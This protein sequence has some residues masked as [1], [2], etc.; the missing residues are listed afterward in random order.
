MASHDF[1]ADVQQILHLV[2]HA[3]YS[4]KEVFLRELISNASDALDRV[5]FASLEDTTLRSVEGEAGIRIRVD[6][7]AG[8]LTISD[9]GIGLTED[10][11]T[12]HLGT[13][14]RSGTLAFAEAAEAAGGD[15]STLVGQFGVGFYASFMVADKV[16]VHSLSAQADAQPLIWTS[17]GGGTYEIDAGTRA[18]RGTDVILHLR[19]D[20]REFLD[21]TRLRETVRQYS[22]FIEWP[23]EIEGEQANQD[24]ALWTRRPADVD[25]E[26]YTAFYKHISRDWNEPLTHLHLRIE[27]NLTFD[28]ILFIPVQRPFQMDHVGHTVGLQLFQKRVKVLESATDLLPR[29]L[30]FIS[31]V[32]DTPDVDLNISREILQQTPTIRAIK[33]QLTKKLLKKL[34]ELATAAPEVYAQFWSQFG[35]VFKEGIQED[36]DNRDTIVE[37]LRFHTTRPVDPLPMSDD[38]P[39]VADEVQAWRSLAQVKADMKDGQDTIWYLTDAHRD[40]IESSPMLEAFLSRDLEVLL[41]TDP[42]DEWVVM[43]VSTYADTPLLSAAHGDLPDLDEEE[44]DPIAE[45]ASAQ[46]SPLASWMTEL[47]QDHVA[48]VRLSKRLTDSPSVLVNQSGSLGANMERILESARQEV[49]K[50]QQVLEINPD[51]PMVQ[52]LVR[53]N[54]EG[55]TGI[56][57]FAQLLLDVAT[58]TDGRVHDPIGF[59]QRLETLMD[60]A[61]Q[62][63]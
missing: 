42:V 6:A 26:D 16:E 47:L 45:A 46:A 30:R 53:L 3:L 29:Y 18:Q 7:E 2:T 44:D 11:A 27:G 8:T 62:A 13:I 19:E 50:K 28:A 15:A 35:H 5:R 56:E 33:R 9:D 14:A 40:R 32:V 36:P 43:H 51:H 17:T 61:S 55:V 38:A 10:E 59:V 22:D 31:G 23:I 4:E 57:P 21:T 52:T 48:E 58:I 54:A 60:K 49:Q 12:R 63:L 20:A 25:P 34:G 41:L 39:A 1:Q 37:L 24:I